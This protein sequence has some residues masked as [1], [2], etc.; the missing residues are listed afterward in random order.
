MY[1]LN[2]NSLMILFSS[3]TILLSIIITV[4]HRQFHF[5]RDYLSLR[6]I[7]PFTG[8]LLLIQHILFIFP[9]VLLIFSFVIVRMNKD[10]K[11]LPP[12]IML[13]LTF[14][15]ISIIANGDGLVEYHF[16]IFMVIALIAFFDQIRLVV[17]S[18]II[19]AVQHVVGYFYIPELVCG[20]S[21]YQFSL[22]LIHAVFLLLMSSATILFIYTKQRNT[23]QFEETVALQQEALKEILNGLNKT[24]GSVLDSTTYLSSSSEELL[25]AGQE[26]TSSIQSVVAATNGQ[27]GQLNIGMESVD[28]MLSQ[29][30][31][32]NGKA[33]RVNTTAKDTLREVEK[34]TETVDRMADQMDKIDHSSKIVVRLVN[35]LSSYSF[36]I[37]RNVGLISNIA[38]QTN[39]LALNASIEAARAGEHGKGFAVVANE[40][41]KLALQS[42]ESAADIKTVIQ[43]I[44]EGIGHISDKVH[45]NLTE[46]EKGTELLSRTKSVFGEIIQST[47]H[48]S[49]EIHRISD[50]SAD[51]LSHSADTR[52]ILEQVSSITHTFAHDIE[53][54]LATTEEQTAASHELNDISL[55][56]QTLTE[57]LNEIVQ[58]VTTSIEKESRI[59]F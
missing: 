7:F 49:K 4:L 58:K 15:S 6:G 51:L 47:H 30:I 46:I 48:V 39:H 41:R 55:L 26:I 34:G 44:Q 5:L 19:F 12:L 56:L 2:K 25:S 10:H 9:I 29:I 43:T 50:A 14:S 28:S 17:S 42:N 38:D 16:S 37:D 23:K 32:I 31:Q 24:S 54:V 22:L 33:D 3:V 35:E 27:L 13:T 52:D 59:Q 53:T 20:T 40:V 45:V 11:A 18:T 21:D 1:A 36:D 57:E 8:K